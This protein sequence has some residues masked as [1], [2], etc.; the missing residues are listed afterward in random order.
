[1]CR[2]RYQP[3]C[4][5]RCQLL[6]HPP[7]HPNGRWPLQA[8]PI[9]QHD[10]IWALYLEW[11]EAFGVVATAVKVYRRY[12][13]FDPAHREAYVDYLDQVPRET[14]GLRLGCVETRQS[15]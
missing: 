9:T 10:R 8:L 6:P 13:M 1:M 3:Q 12:L 5:L 11:V 7:T 14:V 2:R 15:A 4:L